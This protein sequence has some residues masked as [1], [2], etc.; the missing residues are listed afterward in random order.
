MSVLILRNE[1]VHYEALGRGRPVIFLHS[2]VGSWRYWI[3]AMQSVSI[4]YRSYALDLWGFGDTARSGTYSIEDQCLLLQEFIESLGIGRLALIGHG[5]GALVAFHYTAAHPDQIDRLLMV[6]LPWEKGD[7]NQ[8]LEH[9]SIPDL[10]EWLLSRLST[11][12]AVRLEAPKADRQA[13]LTSLQDFDHAPVCSRLPQMS[14][15][16]LLVYGWNDIAVTPPTLDDA[17]ALP[18]N[19]HLIGFDDSGHYPMLDESA[20]F[21]RLLMDFLTLS[22]GE[23]PKDLQLKE[24]WKRRV[25]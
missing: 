8:R 9:G 2:W 17:A 16:Y 7:I 23:S 11:A 12:D 6:S 21:N 18:E 25:R 22:S 19:A 1:I 10:V 5:L 4:S 13:V 15:P 14:T 3:P 24:E 20:K